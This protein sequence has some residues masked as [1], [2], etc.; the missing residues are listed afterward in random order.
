[1]KLTNSPVDKVNLFGRPFFIKRDDLLHP[2]FS[3]N[4]ARKFKA[5]LDND[6]PAVKQL[7]GFGSCQANSLYSLSSLAQSKSWSFSFFVDRIPEHLKSNPIGNY[8]AALVQ[9][10]DVQVF[11]VALKGDVEKEAWLRQK[12]ANNPEVLV[13]PE[14]GR[15]DLA[16]YGVH[17][18][19]E[20][21]TQWALEKNQIPLTVFLPSGTG[22]TALFLQEFFTSKN[23]DIQVL[24]CAVVGDVQYLKHQFN[25]LIDNDHLYPEI[26]STPQR[27]HFGKLNKKLYDTWC[28]A[29]MSG[30]EFELLYDPVGLITLKHH[31]HELMN[32][33]ILYIHQ[34]GILANE[35]MLLRYKRKY[36]IE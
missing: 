13:V 33:S 2:K 8:K 14:G 26:L 17:Q 5:L 29:N 21:I 4:K 32:T 24:T 19:A 7:V 25:L 9:G 30:I 31:L 36:N 12:Y 28:E 11:P 34:G 6:F 27:F 15:S 3:G 16:R 35:T 18:L 22:T 1:M 23:I 20:E 10:A